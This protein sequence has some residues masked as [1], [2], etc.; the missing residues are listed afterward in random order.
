M[1]PLLTVDVPLPFPLLKVFSSAGDLHM[2]HCD[3]RTQNGNH[4]L[5]T[6]ESII[7]GNN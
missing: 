2:A 4:L 1:D 6:N 7:D 5:I 3:S